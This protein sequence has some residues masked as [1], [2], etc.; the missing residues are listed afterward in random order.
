MRTFVCIVPETGRPVTTDNG[1]SMQIKERLCAG[2]SIRLFQRTRVKQAYVKGDLE[3]VM[4]GQRYCTC[5][6][7]PRVF[8]GVGLKG[9]TANVE[10]GNEEVWKRRNEPWDYR[11]LDMCSP[12]AVSDC[13]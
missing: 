3:G 6:F 1:E 2:R 12:G 4:R 10:T 8:F 5:A 9:A 7:R 13:L 11:V